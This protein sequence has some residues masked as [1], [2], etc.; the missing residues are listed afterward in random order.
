[1]KT[2]AKEP[3]SL[4]ASD[5][6]FFNGSQNKIELVSCNGGDEAKCKEHLLLINK[7]FHNCDNYRKA[8]L[9]QLSIEELK[10]A[11]YKT[12]ELSDKACLNCSKLFRSTIKESLADLKDELQAMT[13]G[14]FGNKH[15]ELGYNMA[16][17]VL[18]ELEKEPLHKKDENRKSKERYIESYPQKIVI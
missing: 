2:Y 7:N 3:F 17:K 1:M 12:F 13:N 18:L 5:L 15:Y 10:N 8:K 16:E 14:F 4:D 9:F 11:Y 6:E